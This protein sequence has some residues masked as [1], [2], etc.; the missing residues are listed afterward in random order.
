[1][2]FELIYNFLIQVLITKNVKNFLV[3]GNANTCSNGTMLGMSSSNTNNIQ[4]YILEDSQQQLHRAAEIQHNLQLQQQIQWQ[5]QQQQQQNNN[6]AS[7]NNANANSNNTNNAGDACSGS[8]SGNNN[9][10]SKRLSTSS[11]PINWKDPFVQ[12]AISS[13]FNKKIKLQTELRQVCIYKQFYIF[14]N[15]ISVFF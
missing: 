15:F 14:F 11:Q 2:L 4:R 13:Y 10:K 1:M 12:C 5:Q 3:V 9:S 7:N 6:S 8:N